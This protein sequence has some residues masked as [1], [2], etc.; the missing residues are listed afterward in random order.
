M[1]SSLWPSVCHRT[2]GFHVWLI[3]YWAQF[4]I[5]RLGNSSHVIFMVSLHPSPARA[6][7]HWRWTVGHQWFFGS[8]L[9]GNTRNTWKVAWICCVYKHKFIGSGWGA[10]LQVTMLHVHKRR[11]RRACVPVRRWKFWALIVLQR[12]RDGLGWINTG[13]LTR[14][15]LDNVFYTKDL[16]PKMTWM[17]IIHLDGYESRKS[18]V[19]AATYTRGSWNITVIRM[20]LWKSSPFGM[21][22]QL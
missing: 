20:Q 1:F 16:R 10:S 4:L 7:T 15:L 2:P 5:I 9:P 18:M 12:R 11:L 17:I 22:L 3:S 13:D 14:S 19:T 21:R 8:S 6:F